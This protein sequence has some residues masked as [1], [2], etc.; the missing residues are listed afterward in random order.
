[1]NPMLKPNSSAAII[2]FA[3]FNHLSSFYNNYLINIIFSFRI[4]ELIQSN[5]LEKI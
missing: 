3:V 5:V 2:F 4:L 1:M